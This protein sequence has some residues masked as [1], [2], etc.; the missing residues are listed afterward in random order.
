[1]KVSSENV[2][3]RLRKLAHDLEESHKEVLAKITPPV[4]VL[5]YIPETGER[6]SFLVGN[7]CIKEVSHADDVKDRISINYKDFLHLLEKPQRILNYL[8]NGKVK[9]EGDFKRVLNILSGLA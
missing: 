9:I 2:R 6:M 3:L 7:G 8:M 1:M 5:L 4:L